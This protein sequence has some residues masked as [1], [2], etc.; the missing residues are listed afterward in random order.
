M[1][2]RRIIHSFWVLGLFSEANCGELLNFRGVSI[3]CNSYF[4]FCE[5]WCWRGWIMHDLFG[6]NA[7]DTSLDHHSHSWC[8]GIRLWRRHT[9]YTKVSSKN[10]NLPMNQKLHESRN[11][12]LKRDCVCVFYSGDE[13]GT[14]KST[15]GDGIG[16]VGIVF[17][18]TWHKRHKLRIRNLRIH[19]SSDQL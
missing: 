7:L 13:I 15:C 18:R 9:L 10:S 8:C 17:I 16:S 6:C 1:V 14:L 4:D 12:L 3:Q 2:G 5:M 19:L 11:V